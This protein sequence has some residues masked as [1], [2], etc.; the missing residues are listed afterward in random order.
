MQLKM[1]IEITNDTIYFL[2]GGN[3]VANYPKA[4]FTL[5]QAV[6]DFEENY[7]PTLD[8]EE[9]ENTTTLFNWFKVVAQSYI[10]PSCNKEH[11]IDLSFKDTTN[12]HSGTEYK[13]ESCNETVVFDLEESRY[14]E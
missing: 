3:A 6:A 14:E 2:I 5:Q 7:I 12:L 13:C 8:E 10:C 1:E 11:D 9:P 4:D